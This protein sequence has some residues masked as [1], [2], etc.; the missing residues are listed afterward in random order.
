[1]E[2]RLTRTEMLFSLGF[3][4]MLIVAVGAFFYGV[5]VG[6]DKTEAKFV[7]NTKSL[8]GKTT[9]IG[10]YQQQDLVSF[11][12]TVFLPYREFQTEWFDTIHK[13][14]TS[15]ISDVSSALK[16]LASIASQK[17]AEAEQAAVPNSSPL[18]QSAQL[19]F[20]KSLKLFS[21]NAKRAAGS[22]KDMEAGALIKSL[23]KDAYYV[24]GVKFALSGQQAYYTSMQ[25]WG[26]SVNP[27]IPSTYSSNASLS[28]KSWNALPL[29]IKNKL[30][31]DELT[32][33]KLLAPFYPQDL[34]AR[35]D[36]FIGSGQAANM[37]KG[38]VTSVVDLLIR[39]DAVR[40]GDFA[41]S[42]A[43]LYTKQLLPQ[44]PFFFPEK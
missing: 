3:L 8:S 4:F 40:Q 36:Q 6:S 11:Y 43:E 44:L 39:T 33:R 29:T 37:N 10:S 14:S 42:K 13:L 31:A 30:M 32:T 20:L 5:Q 1:M 28:I 22:S 24:D 21:E 17:Y 27:N 18:L 35:V 16:E 25:K 9:K 26:A 2:K 34:T 15:Q 19:D 23:Q 12:H 41:D 7:E 38:T